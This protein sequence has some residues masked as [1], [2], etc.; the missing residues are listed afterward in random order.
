MMNSKGDNGECKLVDFGLSKILDEDE[1]TDDPF[2]TLAYVAPEVLLHK[3]YT[4]KVDLYSL[5]VIAH[6]LLTGTLPFD[7]ED[8][9]E[10]I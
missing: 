9:Q 2:G 8:D 5:G 6:L 4:S 3:P 1:K 10:T 7:D